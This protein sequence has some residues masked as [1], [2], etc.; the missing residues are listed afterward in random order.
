MGNLAIAI[1]GSAIFGTIGTFCTKEASRNMNNIFHMIIK[2]PLK[3]TIT[4]KA[5][6]SIF[7]AK[8]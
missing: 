1:T 5:F 3:D 7:K 6:E 4:T 2:K 8:A